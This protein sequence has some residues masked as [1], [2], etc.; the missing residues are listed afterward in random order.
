MENAQKLSWEKPVCIPIRGYFPFCLATD[1]PFVEVSRL[2][3]SILQGPI[4]RIM[5][6]IG[7]LKVFSVLAESPCE[8]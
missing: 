2:F 3:R 4:P 8:N 5:E 1:T 7:Y 6:E